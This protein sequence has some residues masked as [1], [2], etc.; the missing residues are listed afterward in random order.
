MLHRRFWRNDFKLMKMFSVNKEILLL[1]LTRRHENIV[2]HYST[3]DSKVL[4]SMDIIIIA[5]HLYSYM[6]V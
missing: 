2:P 6:K 5:M 1:T 4:I 3:G